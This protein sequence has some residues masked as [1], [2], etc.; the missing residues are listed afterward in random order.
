MCVCVCVW[1]RK[2]LKRQTAEG[3]RLR[4]Y[5][6]RAIFCIVLL[7]VSKWTKEAEGNHA[8][9]IKKRMSKRMI[10]RREI[11]LRFLLISRFTRRKVDRWRN[12]SIRNNSLSLRMDKVNDW[13]VEQYDLKL[14]H[15]FFF[16][17]SFLL[18]VRR[19]EI[20]KFIYL[21]DFM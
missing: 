5:S 1:W 6:N 4:R 7:F 9:R 16:F 11:G 18:I 12:C 17:F 20:K 21:M 8:T 15:T 13:F 14:E 3:N 2:Q 19:E 10:E